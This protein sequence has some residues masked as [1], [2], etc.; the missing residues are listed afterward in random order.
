M[1]ELSVL[2]PA[3]APAWI[4]GPADSGGTS[5]APVGSVV[6]MGRGLG[7]SVAWVPLSPAHLLLGILTRAVRR[8]GPRAAEPGATRWVTP[9][10]DRRE[11]W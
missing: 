10:A 9:E 2:L 11:Q 1:P 3:V 8:G 5:R 4:A 6:G 7:G